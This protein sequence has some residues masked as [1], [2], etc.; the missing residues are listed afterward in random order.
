MTEYEALGKYGAEIL[1]NSNPANTNS[2]YCAI[3]FLEDSTATLTSS[4]WSAGSSGGST[5]GLTY[6]KG[7]TVFGRFTAV[8]LSSGKAIC[9]KGAKL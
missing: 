3:T 9:Y 2:I 4:N 8:T 1:S 6:P 7:L 5:A